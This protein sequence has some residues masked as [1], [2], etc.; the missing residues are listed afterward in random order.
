MKTHQGHGHRGSSL[1]K[2]A[3]KR[4]LFVDA[5][6]AG[7][8]SCAFQSLCS[9]P[10][11]L[12]HEQ[13]VGNIP[14]RPYSILDDDQPGFDLTVVNFLEYF[15]V[16]SQLFRVEIDVAEPGA[17]TKVLIELTVDSCGDLFQRPAG[18][19]TTRAGV[20]ITRAE[21]RYS[22]NFR[23]SHL[24]L[25]QWEIPYKDAWIMIIHLVS[26]SYGHK[27]RQAR[28]LKDSKK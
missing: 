16:L 13:I 20:E 14:D 17:A 11:E 1:K 2:A 19:S 23:C 7:S 8:G 6:P 27:I 22:S 5:N 3:P 9:Q 21:N 24:P 12:H 25:L 4:R 18:A 10:L 28:S 26:H 15:R